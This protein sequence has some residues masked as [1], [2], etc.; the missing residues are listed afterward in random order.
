MIDIRIPIG[1]MFSLLGLLLL[2]YG[3]ATRTDVEMYQKAFGN[4]INVFSGCLMLLF[5]AFML[6][7]AFFRK[8]K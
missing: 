6:F 5:G 2:L 7:M 1:F 8:R 3:F 4:N